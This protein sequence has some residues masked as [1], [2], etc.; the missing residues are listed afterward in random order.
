MKRREYIATNQK[1]KGSPVH[2][3]PALRGVR[4][5]VGTTWGLMY[6]AFPCKFCKRLFPRLEPMTSRSQGD[7]FTTAPRLPFILQ[8]ITSN[9]YFTMTILSQPAEYLQ[10]KI[11][12]R[13][14]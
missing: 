4:G 9:I 1:I 11:C 12:V 7:S 2:E 13:L 14:N 10:I 6:T 5:R 3:A 8:L